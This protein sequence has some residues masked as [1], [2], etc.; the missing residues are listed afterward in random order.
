MRMCKNE[1]TN[2]AFN[3]VNEFDKNQLSDIFYYYGEE[4]NS[5]KIAN[6]IIEFRKKKKNNYHCGFGKFNKA[7][8][9]L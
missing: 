3:I 1:I 6:K 9:Y 2:T 5:K 8:K 4:K 7:S